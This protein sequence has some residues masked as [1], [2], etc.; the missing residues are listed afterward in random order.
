[1]YVS[2]DALTVM[3]GWS[4]AAMLVA[5]VRTLKRIADARTV[6]TA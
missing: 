2:R 1:M 4:W 3:L 5:A 6:L